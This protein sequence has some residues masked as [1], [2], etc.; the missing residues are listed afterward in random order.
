VML[1][2]IRKAKIGVVDA[3]TTVGAASTYCCA[4][5]IIRN[6]MVELM[7]CWKAN[8]FHA[9]ASVGR[10]IPR[11]CKTTI[12]NSAA[13]SERAEMKVTGGIV[14]SPILVSG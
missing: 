1:Q 9:L 3:S 7:L 6:G 11:M 12:R 5:V 10:R 13:I 4:E 14:P 2:V 8:S